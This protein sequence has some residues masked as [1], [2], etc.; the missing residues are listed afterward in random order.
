MHG[1]QAAQIGTCY[2]VKNHEIL[3]NRE[4]DEAEK[5]RLPRLQLHKISQPINNFRAEVV[6]R[7]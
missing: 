2:C 7:Y 4:A 3:R 5:I 6:M 1:S